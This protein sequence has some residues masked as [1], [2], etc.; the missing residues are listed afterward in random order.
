MTKNVQCACAR[1]KIQLVQ[2]Q[3]FKHITWLITWFVV[4][5][6]SF[7]YTLW[8]SSRCHSLENMGLTDWKTIDRFLFRFCVCVFWQKWM[9][10]FCVLFRFSPFRTWKH[11]WI[12]NHIYGILKQ[13]EWTK[14]NNKSEFAQT[15]CT[16]HF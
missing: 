5:G 12:C 13:M 8:I 6:L 2:I 15:F 16:P 14:T 9:K 11:K 1:V 3:N 7:F 4:I 10:T